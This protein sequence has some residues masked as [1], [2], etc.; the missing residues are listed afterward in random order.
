MDKKEPSHE[1]WQAIKQQIDA[2]FWELSKEE[3]MTF[4]KEQITNGVPVFV[5]QINGG[6]VPA[7]E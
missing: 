6:E 5:M 2:G 1:L 3:K 7:T 4:A